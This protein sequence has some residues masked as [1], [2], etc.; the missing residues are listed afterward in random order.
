MIG[1]TVG[2]Y[3]IIEKLGRGGMGTVFKAVDETLDREVAVKAVNAG[4]LEEEALKRFRAEAMMLAKLNHPRIATVYE[5]TRSDDELLMVMEFVAGETFEALVARTGALPVERAIALCMQV[6]DALGH[7]HE[8]GIVH[9]DL[10]PANLMVTRSGDVKVMDFGIARVLGTEH[11]TTDGFMMGTPAYMAPEQV[12]AGE[13]DRR[14]DLYSVGVVLYRLVTGRLPFKADTAFAMIQ[15]QLSDPPTPLR[16]VRPDLPEWLEVVLTR[17]LSK[18]PDDRYQSAALF[19][20]ALEAGLGGASATSLKRVP[21]ELAETMLAKTPTALP[22][23]ASTPAPAPPQTPA[24]RTPPAEATVT[25][26]KPQLA[27]AGVLLLVL[28]G[29]VAVLA[30]VALRRPF[31]INALPQGSTAAAPAPPEPAPPAEPVA[32]PAPD[33][34]AAVEAAATPDTPPAAAVPATPEPGSATRPAPKPSASA[35]AAGDKSKAAAKAPAPLPAEEAAPPLAALPSGAAPAPLVE[36]PVVTVTFTDVKALVPDGDGAKEADVSFALEGSALVVRR[37]PDKAVVKSVPYSAI[38]SAIYVEA[39]NPRGSD[40]AGLAAIPG[41]YGNRS[42]FLSRSKHW[43]TLQSKDEF[44]ILRFDKDQVPP[45]LSAL[46]MHAHLKVQK[47]DSAD[48]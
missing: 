11:L 27:M 23:P 28:V 43:L 46:E 7:A 10:K 36:T 47:P 6:L 31:P 40:R 44:L 20:E 48:R 38:Q 39:K 30:Y 25:L 42:S 19:R 18:L 22:R 32:P 26:R 34:P 4:A 33:Q 12:R 5:L 13:I 35:R 17:A 14:A 3:K 29:A 45:I 2:K 9:R 1:K 37:L 16:E 21:V 41:P 15:S 8:A 24:P